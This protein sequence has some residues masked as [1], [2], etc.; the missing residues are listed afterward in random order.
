MNTPSEK[1]RYYAVDALRGL[2]I[3]LM[4]AYHFGY[5]LVMFRIAPSALKETRRPRKRIFTNRA[6]G[7]MLRPRTETLREERG[8]RGT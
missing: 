4:I 8:W 3:L 1:R 6:N 5:N 2:S 7:N